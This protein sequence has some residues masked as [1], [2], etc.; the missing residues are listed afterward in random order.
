MDKQTWV[1]RLEAL[2]TFSTLPTDTMYKMFSTCRKPVLK[3]EASLTEQAKLIGLS[4][5]CDTSSNI[6][7]EFKSLSG[8]WLNIG[9]LSNIYQDQA[10]HYVWS[11]VKESILHLYPLLNAKVGETKTKIHSD[12]RYYIADFELAK[13]IEYQNGNCDFETTEGL[14]NAIFLVKTIEANMRREPVKN[15]K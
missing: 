1:D 13:I 15:V 2:K 8:V 5:K 7:K 14:L 6:N 4:I 10:R 3:K 12:L 11:V 9:R